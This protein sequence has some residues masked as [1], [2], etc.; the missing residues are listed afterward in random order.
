MSNDEKRLATV[1]ATRSGSERQFGTWRTGTCTL[2]VQ[3]TMFVLLVVVHTWL[4]TLGPGYPLAIAAVSSLL[5]IAVILFM[6]LEHAHIL[7][8]DFQM[9][10]I[11]T[12]LHFI[13][14]YSWTHF[15]F[16]LGFSSSLP[17]PLAVISV[18]PL[19]LHYHYFILLCL[20]FSAPSPLTPS[21]T[22]HLPSSVPSPFDLM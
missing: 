21:T 14:G 4:S 20:C 9:P 17:L 3:S 8:T 6:S 13:P 16:P 18:S 10:T 12:A 11:C 7:S 1:W 5:Y 22:I 2:T 19:F 15:L